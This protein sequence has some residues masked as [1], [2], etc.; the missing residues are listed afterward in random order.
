[1]TAAHPRRDR[2]S[3]W[4]VCWGTRAGVRHARRLTA[5][6]SIL[7]PAGLFRGRGLGL[8]ETRLAQQINH[9]A[10]DIGPVAEGELQEGLRHQGQLLVARV[11]DVPL[12]SESKALYIGQGTRPVHALQSQD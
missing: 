7:R 5:A 4:F 12:A 9:E 1:M 6:R 3:F 8:A 11:D 2:A 10:G